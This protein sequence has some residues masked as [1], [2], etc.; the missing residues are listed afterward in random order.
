MEDMG[1]VQPRCDLGHLLDEAALQRLELPGVEARSDLGEDL[2]QSGLAREFG[3]HQEALQPS[4]RADRLSRGDHLG[5]LD[6]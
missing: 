3:D 2:V 5:N 6:A 4:P 1:P